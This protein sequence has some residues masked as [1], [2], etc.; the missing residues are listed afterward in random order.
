MYKHNCSV[1]VKLSVVTG[2]MCFS[3]IIIDAYNSLIYEDHVLLMVHIFTMDND[4]LTG[5]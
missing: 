1:S 5:T 4:V 3:I 2:I